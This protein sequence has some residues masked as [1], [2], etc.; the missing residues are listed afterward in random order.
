MKVE[1]LSWVDK[2]LGERVKHRTTLLKSNNMYLDSGISSIRDSAMMCH[3][4]INEMKI[5]VA[6]SRITRVYLGAFLSGLCLADK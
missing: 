5:V 1:G 2:G 3:L 6:V 4:K